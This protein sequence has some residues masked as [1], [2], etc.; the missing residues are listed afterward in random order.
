MG[1]RRA[2]E[3]AFPTQTRVTSPSRPTGRARASGNAA[4]TAEGLAQASDVCAPTYVCAQPK[5]GSRKCTVC[6]TIVT[7]CALLCAQSTFIHKGCCPGFCTQTTWA[8]GGVQTQSGA[9]RRERARSLP[10][11]LTSEPRV[12][13]ATRPG[14][15]CLHQAASYFQIA[16]LHQLTRNTFNF[17]PFSNCLSLLQFEGFLET[18]GST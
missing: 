11:A 5:G 4:Y 17:Y 2:R 16:C 1:R 10:H 12:Q 15:P 9:L 3:G 6:K 8:G 7:H 18:I 13:N 14:Q